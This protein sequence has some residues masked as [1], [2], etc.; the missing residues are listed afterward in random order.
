MNTNSPITMTGT[1]AAIAF[2]DGYTSLV[3]D[4]DA[5][6]SPNEFG[7]VPVQIS[8]WTRISDTEGDVYPRDDLSRGA[9]LQVTGYVQEGVLIADLV[10]VLSP[11]VPRP[12]DNPAY[13]DVT[14]NVTPIPEQPAA[15]GAIRLFEVVSEFTITDPGQ[16]V[17][18]RWAYDGESGA[19]CQ[20]VV[21]QPMTQTCYQD[22]PPSGEIEITVPLEARGAIGFYLY[23]QI[24][25]AVEQELVILPLTAERGCEYEWF[26]TTAEYEF[27]PLMEC[28]T[29]AP[30]PLRPQAQLFERGFMVRLE[31]PAFGEEAYLIT[32]VPHEI[33]TYYSLGF[34]IVSDD[35]EPGMQ[36][37]DPTL[38]PPEGLYQPSRGFGMLWRGEIEHQ[39][40]GG[41]ITLDGLEVLGWATSEVFEHDAFYQCYEST[42]GRPGGCMMQGPNG[43]IFSVQ[44]PQQ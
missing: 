26:F 43:E 20:H 35:W 24:P 7:Y 30:T 17:T 40:M 34:D 29:T 33:P 28:A 32:I 6:I 11:G 10:V 12:E 39:I 4:E 23:V 2:S 22:L 38:S 3:P 16:T 37:T 41:A 8:E 13:T 5:P 25:D 27:K 18:L 15:D 44:I 14:G 1:A 36:E 31:D 42:H 19:I 21:P 9:H